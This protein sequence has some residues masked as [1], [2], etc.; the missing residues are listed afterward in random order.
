VSGVV[1]KVLRKVKPAEHDGLVL[2]ALG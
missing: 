2:A 1:Q